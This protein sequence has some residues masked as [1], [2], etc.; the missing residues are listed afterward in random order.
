VCFEF[1]E[2]G[3]SYPNAKF[4]YSFNEA[5]NLVINL[6]NILNI[7]KATLAFSCCNGFYAIKTAESFPSKIHR[8]FLSQTPSLNAM[9]LWTNN[10]IPQPLKFP[11]IGQLTAMIQ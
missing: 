5:S 3:F 7:E 10:A 6:I 8:L 9:Q 1:P 2:I 4:K 11:V